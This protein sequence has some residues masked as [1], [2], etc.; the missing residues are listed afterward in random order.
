MSIDF[1]LTDAQAELK[2]AARRFA[3]DT[4]SQVRETIHYLPTPES[5]FLAT[6]PFYEELVREGFLRRLIP[7]PFG[8]EG[9]GMVDMAIVAEEF[10]A[11]DANVPLTAFANLLGLMPIFLAGTPEQQKTFVAPF[12]ECRGAPLAALA[13]SEPGGSANY[14]SDAV[15]GGVRTRARLD[16]QQW[17]IDGA[18]QWISGASGWDGKGADL[19]CVVCRTDAGVA[20]QNGV[21]VLLVPGPPAG[22]RVN[23]YHE[24]PGHRGH[25]TSNFTLDQV[26]VPGGNIVGGVGQGLQ[27]VDASFS[28]TAALV[29]VMSLGVL[30]AAFDFTLHFARTQRR[31]GPVPV[32]E[33]QA[34]GYA[35][36][37]AKAAIEAVRSLSY[38]ACFALDRQAP[39]ALEL[40]LHAKVFGSETAVRVITE[41]MRVVGIDSYD[42]ATSPLASLLQ[43]AL[44]FPLFDGGN[45]GVRR[46]QL[47][48][49]MKQD[50]YDS[51]STVFHP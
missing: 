11:E 50:D 20:P 4:L 40:A 37:D 18:K 30:R 48:E 6:R 36:A 16:G 10:Y 49:L 35:L 15:G 47:H 13:S 43:D 27:V 28:A 7:Q 33:H 14:H 38:R 5:R 19:L 24:S 3:R 29:G 32:I 31:G 1:T 51:L 8:G 42:H 26:R 21:S 9:G 46:R 44:A 17:V 25:L 2:T 45:M 23:R 22:F 39:E 41:L 12:L 34:V